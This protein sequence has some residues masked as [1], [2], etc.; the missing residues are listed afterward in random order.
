MKEFGFC[1]RLYGNQINGTH[2]IALYNHR[3][4]LPESFYSTKQFTVINIG[5][6][7]QL[8]VL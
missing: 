4:E 2:Q 1:R 3:W 7:N 5:I 8:H 6:F